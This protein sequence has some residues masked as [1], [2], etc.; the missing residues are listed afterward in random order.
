[1]L[2]IRQGKRNERARQRSKR[3]DGKSE[4]GKSCVTH[5]RTGSGG[6]QEFS[7][8]RKWKHREDNK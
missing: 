7:E 8:E 6:N 2:V 1:M 4:T 3:E 5:G